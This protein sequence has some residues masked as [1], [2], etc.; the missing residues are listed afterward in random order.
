MASSPFGPALRALMGSKRRSPLTQVR[1]G[2]RDV[3]RVADDQVE[4]AIGVIDRLPPVAGAKGHRRTERCGVGLC[5]RQGGWRDVAGGDRRVGPLQRQ[6]HREDATARAKIQY[7]R[8]GCVRD[9]G[10]GEL[11]QHLG[12]RPRNQHRRADYERTAIEFPGPSQ[13]GDRF[14]THAAIDQGLKSRQ[15]GFVN[16]VQPVS[17]QPFRGPAGSGGEQDAGLEPTEAAG[18]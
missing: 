14:A 7:P 5:H 12:I 13:V 18:Q 9:P 15:A 16:F 3:G 10:K 8:R 6:G 11:D 2:C 17:N 1:V 4:P